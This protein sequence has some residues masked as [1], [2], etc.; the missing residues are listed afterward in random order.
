MVAIAVTAA[1]LACGDAEKPPHPSILLITIDTLRAD[2]LA[3]TAL[4]NSPVL[5]KL[6]ARGTRFNWAFSAAPTTAPSHVSLLT[7]KYPGFHSVG[8]RNGDQ[9]LHESAITLAEVLEQHGYATKA[10]L[11]NPMLKTRLGLAQGFDSY[12]DEMLGAEL[13][14]GVSEQYADRAIDKA[15]AWLEAKPKGPFFLWLHLQDPHGPYN[16][17]S[18]IQCNSPLP[19]VEGAA[20]LPVGAT[21]MGD[22]EIPAYQAIE[23]VH[24]V[25]T[26]RHNYACEIAFLDRELGR[27]MDRLAHEPNFGE[28]LILLTSDHGEAMGE[29][30]FWFAHGHSIAIDQVHVPLIAVGPGFPAAKLVETPVSNVSIFATAIDVLGLDVGDQLRSTLVGPSLAAVARSDTAEAG[31]PVF[32]ESMTQLGLIH[33]NAFL[34]KDREFEEAWWEEQIANSGGRRKRQGEHFIESLVASREG[35][36]GTRAE[37]MAELAA[38]TQRVNDAEQALAPLREATPQLSNAEEEA[39]RALGYVE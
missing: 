15:L 17:P 14:R 39:L 13:N 38:Y 35:A 19:A 6:A 5:A 25:A 3:G 28:M 2:H 11:S 4:Q 23:G 18:E 24:E 37:L 26:Y 7:G 34:R 30:G 29:D 1:M 12:D 21:H 32:V 20:R 22:G 9:K 10:I 36:G 33:R 16:P 8:T 27:F 31:T